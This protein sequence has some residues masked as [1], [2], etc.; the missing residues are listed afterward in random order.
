MIISVVRSLDQTSGMKEKQ[1]QNAGLQSHDT[2][3][4]TKGH[5]DQQPASGTKLWGIVLEDSYE[6]R[7]RIGDWTARG[8]A[9]T[10]FCRKNASSLRPCGEQLV[11]K[12]PQALPSSS[13]TPSPPHLHGQGTKVGTRSSAWDRSSLRKSLPP[14]AL[15]SRNAQHQLQGRLPPA[16]PEHTAHEGLCSLQ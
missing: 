13:G 16:K 10:P 4:A 9:G 8:P 14:R 12:T 3:T 11:R 6:N 7:L 5:T 15:L 1:S 2:L